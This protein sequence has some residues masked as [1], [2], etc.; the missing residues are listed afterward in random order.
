LSFPA[1][2]DTCVLYSGV[3]NDL[4]L[5]LAE[6]G[7]F[8]PLWSSDVMAELRKN[9]VRCFPED[10]VD[11]RLAAMQRAFPDAM[12]DGYENLVSG[13]LCDPKDRHVLAAAV[14]ANAELLVT[15]NL[16]DFPSA[17]TDAFDIEVVNPDDFL[18]DQLDLFPG[19]TLRA[20]RDLVDDYSNPEISLEELLQR[21]SRAGVP[22]FAQELNSRFME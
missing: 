12:V 5:R 22:K 21:L 6:R 1:F 14:R 9:L 11:R 20:L 16:R 13:M 4:L 7:A 3:L 18:L 8:R 17:S 19:L 2:F 10:A 15:F